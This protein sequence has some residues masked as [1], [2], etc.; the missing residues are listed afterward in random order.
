MNLHQHQNRDMSAVE[1]NGF[2][3]L[4][5]QEYPTCVLAL[6][7]IRI[8]T[9]LILMCNSEKLGRRGCVQTFFLPNI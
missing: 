3:L 2:M 4:R 1:V 5:A 8:G 6:L 7:E 9:V